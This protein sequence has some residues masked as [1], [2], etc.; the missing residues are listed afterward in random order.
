MYPG[1][2]E[3]MMSSCTEYVGT[4]IAWPDFLAGLKG[5]LKSTQSHFCTSM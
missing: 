5:N 3:R 2:I 1:Q 4:V